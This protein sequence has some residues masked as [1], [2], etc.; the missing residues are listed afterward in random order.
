MTNLW[1]RLAGIMRFQPC[2]I[3]GDGGAGAGAGAGSGAGAGAGAGS[4]AGAGGGNTETPAT[5]VTPPA[6]T[7][8]TAGAGAPAATQTISSSLTDDKGKPVREL[9]ETSEAFLARYREHQK[10][11]PPVAEPAAKTAEQLAQEAER[12]R[13]AAGETPEQK[14]AREKA[15]AAAAAA[16]ETPEQKAAREKAT[17]DEADRQ[18]AA[19]AAGPDIY[20]FAPIPAEALSAALKKDPAKTAAFLEASGLT[21]D[22]LFANSKLASRAT[23]YMQAG[24]PTIEAAKHAV[25]KARAFHTLDDSFTNLKAGDVQGTGKFLNDVLLPLSYLRDEN[26]Q[27]RIDPESKMPLTDGSVFTFM[28]NVISVKGDFRA[29]QIAREGTEQAI[30]HV[31]N[32]PDVAPVLDACLAIGKKIGGEKGDAIQAAVLTLK[33]CG[34]AGSVSDEDLPQDVKDRLAKADQTK[35]DADKQRRELDERQ[36]AEFDTK[37]NTFKE[38]VL[39]ESSTGID[40]IIGTFL[41]TTSLKDEKFVRPVVIQKIR[42]ALYDNMAADP[43]YLSQRDAITVGGPNARTHK[44][45]LDLNLS[46]AKARLRTVAS[47]IFAEAGV[48]ILSKAAQRKQELEGQQRKSQMETH[49]GTTTALPA[50]AA[51]QD[52]HEVIA[53]ARQNLRER[54]EEIT[55]ESLLRERRKLMAGSA[56]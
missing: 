36:A 14:A 41:D 10:A 7:S 31:M 2:A 3:D 13:A 18:A 37:V 16:N 51:S 21:E 48:T 53:Q 22:Q 29:K 49:G 23:E 44:S 27:V 28:D 45:W 1:M 12:A 47:P 17:K 32:A 34:K 35:A 46:E 54:G 9:G 52:P 39:A 6:A 33:Q 24:L 38:E 56:A 55:T 40:K 4:G 11:N 5:K 19:A 25:A 8:V 15:A 43:L 20:D 30:G 42:A 50:A 26:G